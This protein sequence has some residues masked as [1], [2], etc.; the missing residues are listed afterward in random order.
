MG[1]NNRIITIFRQLTALSLNVEELT[2][3]DEQIPVV[4]CNLE[5]IFSPNFFDSMEHLLVHLTY[6]ALIV[7]PVHYRWMYPP[8][9]YINLKN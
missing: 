5:K 7:G 6:E 3:M 4:L 9:K 2:V 1:S 8:E